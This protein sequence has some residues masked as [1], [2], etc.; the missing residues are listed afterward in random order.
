MV[1]IVVSYNIANDQFSAQIFFNLS[2][3]VCG[4]VF[5]HRVIVTYAVSS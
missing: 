3:L 5:V 1:F 2:R 4:V